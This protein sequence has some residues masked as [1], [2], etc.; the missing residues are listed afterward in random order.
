MGKGPEAENLPWTGESRAIMLYVR[1][2]P[3]LADIIGERRLE[4][5]LRTM[6]DYLRHVILQDLLGGSQKRRGRKSLGIKEED[7]PWYGEDKEYSLY[8]RVEPSLAD[9]FYERAD[10][11]GF[12]TGGGFLYWLIVNDLVLGDP[13][14]K[15]R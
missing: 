4:L 15:K 1:V 13:P 9:T 3:T 2:E 5:T 14:S 11:A 6:S 12:S 8:L 10:E 7:A